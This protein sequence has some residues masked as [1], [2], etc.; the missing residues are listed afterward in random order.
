MLEGGNVVD[1][2]LV[3]HRNGLTDGWKQIRVCG[4]L[5]QLVLECMDAA[6]VCGADAHNLPCVCVRVGIFKHNNRNQ[7]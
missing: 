1:Q 5:Q 7:P 4:P 2:T 3:G 6:H